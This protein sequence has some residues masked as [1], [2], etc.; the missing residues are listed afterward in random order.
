MTGA[1]IDST[2]NCVCSVY[3]LFWPAS[4]LGSKIRGCWAI[5]GVLV[6]WSQSSDVDSHPDRVS[7]TWCV[8]GTRIPAQAVIDNAEDGYTAEQVVAKIYPSLP[9]EP[10]RRIIAF[11]RMHGPTP[12]A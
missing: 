5:G 2:A 6:D 8:K 9:L 10:A 7:G 4:R 1:Q 11:A 3:V 12:A